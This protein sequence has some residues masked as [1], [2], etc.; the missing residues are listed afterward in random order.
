MDKKQKEWLAERDNRERRLDRQAENGKVKSIHEC[1]YGP[2]CKLK[3][4]KC[5]WRTRPFGYIA[6]HQAG[7]WVAKVTGRLGRT[8]KEGGDVICFNQ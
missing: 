1:M 3:E 7:G 6:T 5:H 2:Q 4:A 8:N